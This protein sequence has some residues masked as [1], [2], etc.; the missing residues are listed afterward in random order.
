MAAAGIDVVLLLLV[1]KEHLVESTGSARYDCVDIS[2]HVVSSM[3]QL[4]VPGRSI[5]HC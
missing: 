2:Y 3:S 1:E 5:A 4:D